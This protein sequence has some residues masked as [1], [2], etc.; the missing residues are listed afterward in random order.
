M[1]PDFGP[2]Y[3]DAHLHLQDARL[4]PHLDDIA[5]ELR[6]RA[7]SR[8][9]VAGTRETDWP[10]VA[11]LAER[12]P[13]VMPCYGL[14]PWYLADRTPD[15]EPALA[16]FLSRPGTAAV[17]EIGL[18]KWIR[19]HRIEEQETVFRAQL[20][21]A[22]RLGLPVVIHCLRAWGR[23]LAVLRDEATFPAGFLL[24]SYAGPAEMTDDFASLGGYFS[25]SG[26]FLHPR[27]ADVVE[28]FRRLPRE[29]ILIE[30]DAPDMRLPAEWETCPLVS[31]VGEPINHPANLPGVYRGLAVALGIDV[32]SLSGQVAANFHRL[33]GFAGIGNPL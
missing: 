26:Y 25:F 1:S 20:R 22:A 11:R 28:T 31:P 12:F 16:D 18:D 17:G 3:L 8:W 6:R 9:V 21:L 2:V 33:F 24:H 23:L 7:V 5:A 14:H 32:G 4:R 27:K 30:T 29:R 10:E 13:E 19:D 15:W